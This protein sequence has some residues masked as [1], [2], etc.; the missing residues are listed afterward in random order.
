[1]ADALIFHIASHE[2]WAA[3]R[4]HGVY[5][6]DS[7]ATEGFIHCSNAHQYVWVA[8]QRF[9]G[10]TDLVVLHID[11]A[12]LGVEIRHEN[13]E[14]GTDLFPHVYG[15]IPVA[16]VVDVTPMR[17][18]P[19]GSFGDAEGPGRVDVRPREGP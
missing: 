14:G 1:M 4:A 16:A 17:P 2:A 8:N 19:D 5:T 9:R 10:R 3:A 6:V 13:L 12:R 15:K 7:L 11:P 18:G